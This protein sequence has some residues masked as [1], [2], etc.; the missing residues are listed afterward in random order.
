MTSDSD[1]RSTGK[2]VPGSRPSPTI[3]RLFTCE[4]W[5]PESADPAKTTRPG[6]RQQR[7]A[8][9]RDEN[10]DDPGPAAA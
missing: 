1:E 2:P 10:D 9:G 5:Q 7:P 8:S 4:E 6:G 3:L